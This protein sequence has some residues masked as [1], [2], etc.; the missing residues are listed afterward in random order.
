MPMDESTTEQTI[1]AHLWEV[2][3]SNM[4][5]PP[6]PQLREAGHQAADLIVSLRLSF[7]TH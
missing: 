1:A 7:L 4:G 6:S 3:T 5:M 2:A